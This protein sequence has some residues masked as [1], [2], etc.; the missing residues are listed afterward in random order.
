MA[1]GLLQLFP[2]ERRDFWSRTAALQDR[3]QEIRLRADRP[4][5]VILDGQEYGLDRGGELTDKPALGY[6]PGKEELQNLLSHICQYSLYAFEDELKQG[7]LTVAGGH[8]IGV[9]G[10]VVLE[11]NCVRTIKHISYMNIRVAHE[12]RG[13]ADGVLPW[14]YQEGR[15]KNT[16]IISP[17]GCGKTTLLRDLIRQ[18]SNGNGCGSGLCVGVVDERSEL[19]GTY[20]GT[21]QNDLGF[22]TDVLDACPKALGMMLLLRSMSPQVIAVDE[23]GGREDVDALKTAAACGSRILATIHGES[24]RDIGGKMALQ[25]IFVNR[26][27]ERFLLL[28][29]REGRCEVIKKWKKEEAYAEILRECDD[30]CGKS[31]AGIVV[32]AA[33]V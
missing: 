33:D 4:V 29:R 30:S 23:L 13:A 7:F 11:G 14:V 18:V 17:P 31:G 32:S 22:R 5:L 9:A 10:Q 19:A 25:D 28:G 26:L 24:L 2:G 8:R 15:L 12:V 21:P 16:L 6:C 20:L 1:G 3:L 27:F